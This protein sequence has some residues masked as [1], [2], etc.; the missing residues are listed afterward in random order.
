MRIAKWIIAGGISYLS[1]FWIK[2]FFISL[3]VSIIFWYLSLII[4]NKLI[5]E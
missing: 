2:N 4:L 5:E 1:S 3:I